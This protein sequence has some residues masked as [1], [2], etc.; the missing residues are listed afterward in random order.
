MFDIYESDFKLRG[1]QRA[2]TASPVMVIPESDLGLRK[3]ND[4]LTETIVQPQELP[5][6]V[7]VGDE[8]SG[9]GAGSLRSARRPTDD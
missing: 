8:E 1:K 4:K 7:S 9:H 6:E 2:S 5:V 3:D